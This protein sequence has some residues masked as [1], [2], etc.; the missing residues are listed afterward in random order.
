MRP[1]Q[2]W[3]HR[4]GHRP[5]RRR[6]WSSRRTTGASRSGTGRTRDGAFVIVALHSTNTTEWLAIPADDPAGRARVVIPRREGIE[7]AVDH[8]TPAAGGGGWFI[9]LTNDEA[10]DFRVVAAPDAQLGRGTKTGARS[11]RTGPGVRIEDV[12]AFSDSLVLSERA[13]AE[14]AVR[15]L[16]LA[17]GGTPTRSGGDL[18]A[19]EVGSSPRPSSPRRSGWAPT[20][21]PT[22]PRCASAAPRW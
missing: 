12:D 13:E 5:R 9:V 7:Y 19:S 11:C 21:S 8:L 15:V 2:L 4:L 10:R 22:S 14:T 1:H 16:P 6:R 17:A 18:L 3:R 20:P